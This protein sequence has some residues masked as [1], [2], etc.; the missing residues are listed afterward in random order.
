VKGKNS[1]NNPKILS[2]SN[3]RRLP[4]KKQMPGVEKRIKKS[5]HALAIVGSPP[6]ARTKKTQLCTTAGT[7]HQQPTTSGRYKQMTQ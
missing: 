3:K 1:A 6:I 4:E 7:N 5:N 2:F